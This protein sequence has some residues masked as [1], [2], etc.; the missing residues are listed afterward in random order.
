MKTKIVELRPYMLGESV[1]I[2]KMFQEVPEKEEYNQTNEFYGLDPESTRIKICEMMQKEYCINTKTAESPSIIYV[3]Y[4]DDRPVGF[5]GMKMKINRYWVVHSAT[6]WYKIR[7]SE[8]GKGYGTRLVDKL[9][10]RANDF[11]LTYLNAST[12]IDNYASRRI[13]VKNGFSISNQ[14]SNTIFY[15]LQLK[16]EPIITPLRS[17]N[18]FYK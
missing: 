1:E 16:E 4:V 9:V 13:L 8:R 6:I 2:Y 18:K 11:G 5:A 10:K 15:K 12:S 3:F 14:E 7:P 17:K